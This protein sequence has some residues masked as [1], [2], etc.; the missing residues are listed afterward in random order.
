VPGSLLKGKV[1]DENK[2]PAKN[3][4]IKFS[5][6]GSVITTNSGEFVIE[7]P[8]G[9]F[10]AEIELADNK[11]SILYPVDRRIALSSDPSYISKVVITNKT[12]GNESTAD[13]AK[14]YIKLENLMKEIGLSQDKLKSMIEEFIRSESEKENI[15]EI[16]LKEAVYREKRNERFSV[17][18]SVIS[19]YIVETHD[20]A[21]S[22][23]NAAR[24]KFSK[25]ESLS[26][27]AASVLS[28]NSAFEEFNNNKFSFAGDVELY[29]ENEGI[30]DSLLS[31]IE[32]A[33]ED[34]HKPN[35]LSLNDE[36]TEINILSDPAFRDD[37]PETKIAEITRLVENNIKQLSLKME[38]FEEKVN[39]VLNM[40]KKEI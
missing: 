27:L 21:Q 16:K 5:N 8:D 31:S 11:L 17:I 25:N 19:K 22:L 13:L 36:I 39:Y 40:L 24:F 29:W 1:Y 18:S 15:E 37:E 12:Q 3:I 38:V 6:I 4:I 14:K 20:L 7:L 32:Y 23:R 35:I 30:S 26:E 9:V 34:I 10:S 28:Y 33:I 2:N